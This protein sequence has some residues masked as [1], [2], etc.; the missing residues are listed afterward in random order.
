MSSSNLAE[1]K[2][3]LWAC[4]MGAGDELEEGAAVCGAV[5]RG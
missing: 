5:G 3:L 4:K 2:E 1:L